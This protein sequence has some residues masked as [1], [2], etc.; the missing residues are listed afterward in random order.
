MPLKTML[1]LEKYQRAIERADLV[2]VI[3]K[4]VQVI[5]PVVD[6]EFDVKATPAIYNALTVS[7]PPLVLEV[8]QQLGDGVV[9]T[10]AMGGTDSLKRATKVVDTGSAAA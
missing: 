9:R 5:G 6:V 4:V 8:Q 1:D 3:G 2:K 7:S 10:V